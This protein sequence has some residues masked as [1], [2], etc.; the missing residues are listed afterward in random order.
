MAKKPSYRRDHEA[1][2]AEIACIVE[3]GDIPY[4]EKKKGIQIAKQKNSTN[5]EISSPRAKKSSKSHSPRILREK[6]AYG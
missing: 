4:M 6:P 2:T 5:H 1:A 3:V